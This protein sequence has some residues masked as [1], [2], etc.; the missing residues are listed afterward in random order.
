M[1]EKSVQELAEF[2]H[3]PGVTAGERALN[4]AAGDTL[5]LRV[6][7][8]GSEGELSV[9][10]DCDGDVTVMCGGKEA[11]KSGN[12]YTF[13]AGPGVVEVSISVSAPAVLSD[14]CLPAGGLQMILR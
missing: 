12:V 9:K 8:K 7:T 4:L 10:V 3:G 6:D 14:V 2:L 11:R 13:A 5:L 1:M